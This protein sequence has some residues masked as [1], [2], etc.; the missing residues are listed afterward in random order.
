[1]EGLIDAASTGACCRPWGVL[2]WT[3]RLGGPG[4]KVLKP[5][6]LS[7]P[8]PLHLGGAGS[9]RPVL[10]GDDLGP[11]EEV[12]GDVLQLVGP[13]ELRPLH[14]MSRGGERPGLLGGAQG[15][16]P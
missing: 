6:G 4:E 3:F 15:V 9:E 13:G 2:P 7:G 12:G 16:L 10:L 1:M 8:W 5:V 11:L 14:H